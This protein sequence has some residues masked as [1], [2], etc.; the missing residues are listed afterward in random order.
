MSKLA[1]ISGAAGGLGKGMALECAARGYDLYLTDLNEPALQ[2]LTTGILRQYDVNVHI[3]ACDLTNQ[4]ACQAMWDEIAGLDQRVSL[5]VNV[6]GLDFEGEFM[7]V[8]TSLLNRIIR[9]NI[10]SVINMTRTALIHRNPAE[11]MTIINVASLAA[12]YPMPVKAVYAA[13]KRFLLDF[14][15]ALNQELR[16]ENVSVTAL[17]PAGM[18]TN[19]DCINSIRSQGL[20]G[21]I[22]TLNV[23]TIARK[24]LDRALAGRKI[25]IPGWINVLLSLAGYL[26]PRTALAWLIHRRWCKTRQQ[27]AAAGIISTFL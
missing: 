11:R 21:M 19:E 2:A 4:E 24:C 16:K 23:S 12:F 22:T 3:K 7:A 8:E 25:Y 6:A 14:S 27:L 5:L 20:A 18:P 17:C 26:V 1:L 9:L 15:I 13:S 10:E